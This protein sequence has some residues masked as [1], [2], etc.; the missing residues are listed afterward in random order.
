MEFKKEPECV[1]GD[2]EREI[3]MKV[4][5]LPEDI[6]PPRSVFRSPATYLLCTPIWLVDE[7]SL[8]DR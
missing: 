7:V 5:N 2:L 8:G 4:C 1:K 6:E 3:V